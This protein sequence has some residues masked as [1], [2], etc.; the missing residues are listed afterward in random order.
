[1]EEKMIKKIFIIA[2][3]LMVMAIFMDCGKGRRSRSS[4]N[5][6]QMKLTASKSGYRKRIQAQ[7]RENDQPKS[8]FEDQ[9]QVDL[10]LDS[11]NRI[12]LE[13]Q[14]V[15]KSLVKSTLK[16]MGRVLAPN[17]RRAII[18]YAFS[19]R[20]IKL[21]VSVGEWVE[22]GES[23]VT[24]E[25]EEVGNA[26]AELF[27][28]MT[29]FELARQSYIREERLFKKDVGAQ[30][31]YLAAEASFQIAK[32]TMDAA[33]K[34]LLFLGFHKNQIDTL[35]KERNI[36]PF[37]TLKSPISGRIVQNSSVPG[38]MIDQSTEIIM[39]MDPTVLWIDAE[40]FEKDLSKIKNG[41]KVEIV[42]PA[43]PDEIFYGQIHYISD[44]VNSTTRTITVRTRV[45]NKDL[46][47]K[48]GMFADIDIFL[49]EKNNAVMIPVKAVL[50]DGDDKIVFVRQG[51]NF[52]L[53]K[54]ELGSKYNGSIEV[55]KGL[56]MG[57]IVVIRGN[58]QL[59]SKMLE[60]AMQHIHVH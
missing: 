51:D 33:E 9:K 27:K 55:L 37:I 48:P 29:D 31:D 42:V 5:K 1:M 43:Y 58:Y 22:K 34:R 19:A 26:K 7:K 18:G 21:L 17:D 47:L 23:L 39:V 32:A 14:K 52:F 40:I 49:E 44:V 10:S 60:K 53:R 36:S 50:D 56:A 45:D 4:E 30:K 12:D 54:V 38:A 2:M 57:E 11:I 6:K 24:L 3:V 15:E 20:I 46:K 25:C 13:T 35:I 41:Q 59:K 28:A 8:F 16:A